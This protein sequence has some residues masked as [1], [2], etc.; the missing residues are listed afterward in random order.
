MPDHP[1]VRLAPAPSGSLHVGSVRTALYNWLHARQQ[2][3]VFLLRIEDT[4]EER[5]SEEATG[6]MLDALSWV[7]LDWDEGPRVGGDHGPYR[8]SE[9]R[10][11]YGAVARRL[12]EAGHL[13][14][15]E[16][17][18]EELQEWRA[19]RQDADQSP[20][21]KAGTVPEPTGER[22]ASL[23]LRT[24]TGGEVAV[25]DLVR[26]E[27]SWD[28][29]T[30]SDPVLVRSDGSATY[31]LANAVDDVAQGISLV[32]RGEDLL[33]VVPRQLLLHDLLV[34]DG[35]IDD[36][37]EEAGLPARA[38]RWQAPQDFAHLS[39]I[40]GDDRKPLS[41][42]HGSVAIQEFARRGFLPE[43]LL[44]YL[45]L[46]GWSPRDGRERLTIDDMIEAFT[47]DHVGSTAAGFDEDK[48]TAFNGERIRELDQ[49]ELGRRLVPYL[50]GTYPPEDEDW[51]ALVTRPPTADELSVLKGLV[52]LV[53]ERMQRLDEVQG[54]A[55]AFLRDDIELREDAVAQVLA[56]DTAPAALRAAREALAELEPWE[57]D[58]IE[59]A[60]RPLADEL[61]IG[62][63]KVAQPV[64]VATTG[65]TVAPPL[66]GSLEV[67]GRETVLGRIDE[68]LPVAEEVAG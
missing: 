42:R 15:D 51:T 66:F 46:L 64:R 43:V 9:R 31:L 45:A 14:R 19:A 11:L 47:F 33:S 35:L 8:Q 17:T 61:G 50:D 48:L 22:P 5:A 2:D 62:F 44:N 65:R 67:M 12:E 59:R 24:P 63:G 18:R 29:E 36:A 34:D 52:P 13:Y 54:Y 25:D 60:L 56:K 58:A 20:V 57:A 27:V 49:V 55:T 28:W 41:K 53:H 68:A 6:E 1:R 37:L 21:I 30:V 32:C 38:D 10:E 3:G 4:D 40:V 39:M 7:G 23:R 26:G 16:R